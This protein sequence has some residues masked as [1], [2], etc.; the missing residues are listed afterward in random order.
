MSTLYS[1][2][3]TNTRERSELAA[4]SY[5]TSREPGL[6]IMAHI[7]KASKL[8]KTG[9]M[10]H[11]FLVVAIRPSKEQLADFAEAQKN[12]AGKE[13]FEP[14]YEGTAFLYLSLHDMWLNAESAALAFTEASRKKDGTY[15][16]DYIAQ[17]VAAGD[18]TQENINRAQEYY[19]KLAE[20]KILAANTPGDVTAAV[21]EQFHKE[22]VKVSIN[23]G[24]FFDLQDWLTGDPTKR[25][26]H[27]DP[28]ALVGCQFSGKVE[29]A[30][31]GNGSEVSRVYS[32]SAR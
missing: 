10:R 2:F 8:D 26:I 28:K 7:E 30:N 13:V 14:D 16:N 24:Q 22:L 31:V 3:Q 5:G 32:R 18:T 21:A 11:S 27:L 20:E 4:G 9:A 29:K 15:G 1:G 19:A 12:G 17:A 23:L 6:K 25:D